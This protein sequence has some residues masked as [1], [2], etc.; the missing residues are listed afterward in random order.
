[1]LKQAIASNDSHNVRR[2][3][4]AGAAYLKRREVKLSAAEQ[5]KTTAAEHQRRC[6]V[7]AKEGR[8]NVREQLAHPSADLRKYMD[9][10]QE[11]TDVGGRLRA[12]ETLRESIRGIFMRIKNANELRR[13]RSKSY[14]TVVYALSAQVCKCLSM[15]CRTKLEMQERAHSAQ[16]ADF[17][18]LG[19]NPYERFRAETMKAAKAAENSRH[20]K[21]AHER[22]EQILKSL[23]LEEQAWGRSL[24]VA[25]VQKVRGAACWWYHCTTWDGRYHITHV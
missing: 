10:C 17:L 18:A 3:R 13:C 8:N 15:H 1:M 5:L 14:A 6:I 2:E 20:E 22:K 9:M 7:A 21:V 4:R 11:A 23:L 19:I 25:A 12:V 16:E 24:K